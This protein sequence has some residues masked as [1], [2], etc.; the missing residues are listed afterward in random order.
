MPTGFALV[1]KGQDH[2]PGTVVGLDVKA[3]PST[4]MFGHGYVQNFSP[5]LAV[6]DYEVPVFHT[7]TREFYHPWG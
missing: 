3:C 7:F 1:K 6:L 4:A 2:Y 5:Q